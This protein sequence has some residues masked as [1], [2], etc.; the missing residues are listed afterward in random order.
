MER[1]RSLEADRWRAKQRRE[2]H[3][4]GVDAD[5]DFTGSDHVGELNERILT[6]D[7]RRLALC[8]VHLRNESVAAISIAC[9]SRNENSQSM[10]LAQLTSELNPSIAAPLLHVAHV[11]AGPWV[12]DSEVRAR[13]SVPA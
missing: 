11:S 1:S 9:A 10:T 7:V 12:K 3:N 6:S 2:V 5:D 4:T 8:R 13:Q